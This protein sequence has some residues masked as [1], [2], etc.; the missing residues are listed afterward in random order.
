MRE[1][2]I[3]SAVRT[4]IGKAIKGSFKDTRP[5]DLLAVVLKAAVERAGVDPEHIDDIVVGT[6][7]PEAEQGMNVGRIAGMLAGLTAR[8]LID[9]HSFLRASACCSVLPSLR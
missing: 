4:P 7:M 6:A 2:A 1:V 8:Y 5:D 9:S 3:V